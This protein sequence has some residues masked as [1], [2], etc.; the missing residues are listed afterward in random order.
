MNLKDLRRLQVRHVMCGHGWNLFQGGILR[1]HVAVPAADRCCPS[2]SGE[3]IGIPRCEAE[4]SEKAFCSGVV[5]NVQGLGYL[6]GGWL[7]SL[8]VKGLCH[9][10]G[11]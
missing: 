7:Q 5:A 10:N 1:R 6:N 9:L 2:T 4:S 8:R 3:G 11:R